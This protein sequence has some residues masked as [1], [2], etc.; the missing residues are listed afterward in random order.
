VFKHKDK[1]RQGMPD[2]EQREAKKTGRPSKYD[3]V[4][5]DQAAVLCKLGATNADL[6]DFFD[7][8]I[9]TIERWSSSKD[10]FCRALKIGK[11]EADERVERSLYH[12]AVGYTFDSEMVKI[13]NDGSV[14]R[15]PTREHVPPDTTAAIFWLKNRDPSNWRD[16]RETDLNHGM[17]D[18]IG[19]FFKRID[20]TSKGLEGL[21][22]QARKPDLETE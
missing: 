1:E 6:A 13:G 9:R 7:V 15:T 12:R 14:Y 11:A 22:G 4:F 21:R 18:D 19:E 16:K 20:G 3:P 8:T 2:E 10:D 17:K 5:A